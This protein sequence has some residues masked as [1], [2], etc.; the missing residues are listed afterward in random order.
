MQGEDGGGWIPREMILGEEATK[1]V[2]DEFV[3]QRGNVANPPTLLLVIEALQRRFFGGEEDGS[4]E[5]REHVLGFLREVFPSLNVWVQWLLTS[6]K[7]DFNATSAA[8]AFRWKGRSVRD[9]KVFL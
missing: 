1:R 7:S 5:D 4:A 2:P 3:T 6:Q 8:S 9:G